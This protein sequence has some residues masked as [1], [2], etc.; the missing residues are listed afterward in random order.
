MH[1]LWALGSGAWIQRKD[2]GRAMVHNPFGM[3]YRAQT[4]VNSLPS[5]DLGGMGDG[6]RG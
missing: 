2:Q 5:A 4:A 1:Q 6:G 3:F